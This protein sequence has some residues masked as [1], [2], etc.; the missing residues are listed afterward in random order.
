MTVVVLLGAPGAGKGTQAAVLRDRLGIPHIATGDLFRAAIRA[1]TP[2]GLAARSDLD[3]GRLVP[4]DLTIGMLVERL[5]RPDAAGG[6]IL[7]GFPRTRAQAVA[8][9]GLLAERRKTVAAALLI[10]VPIEELVARLSGR[11]ICRAAGH[12]YHVVTRPP[13]SPGICDLDGSEL[14]Q[15]DD[16]REE[17]VRARLATQLGALTEVV[18]HYRTAGLLHT[19]DGRQRVETVTEALLAGLPAATPAGS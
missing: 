11:W 19:V 17:T 9:E 12:P 7:D 4:D 10:E 16:D 15:R 6:A 14:Y 5:D 8:L 3:A 13:R 1:G 18:D 2:L